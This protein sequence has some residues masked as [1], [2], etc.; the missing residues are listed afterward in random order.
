MLEALRMVHGAGC[1][2]T[3]LFS[4]NSLDLLIPESLVTKHFVLKTSKDAQGRTVEQVLVT[5]LREAVKHVNCDPQTCEELTLMSQT[6]PHK[7]VNVSGP[8]A[9]V[10]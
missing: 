5:G 7:S 6:V 3:R 10:K 4:R 8:Q 2:H 1:E 9:R